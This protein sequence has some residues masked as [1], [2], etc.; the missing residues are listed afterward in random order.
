MERREPGDGDDGGGRHVQLEEDVAT[1]EDEE[2]RVFGYYSIDKAGKFEVG[3]L[4]ISFVR[5]DDV[6]NIFGAKG[7]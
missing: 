2:I 7:L 6:G 1:P 5:R 4:G 3:E